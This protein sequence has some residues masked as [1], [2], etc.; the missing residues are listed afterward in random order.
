M[1]H[2][3]HSDE[4]QNYRKLK[5]GQFREQQDTEHQETNCLLHDIAQLRPRNVFFRA[6]TIFLVCEPS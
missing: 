3:S 5:L 4:C 2:V 6:Y 1:W